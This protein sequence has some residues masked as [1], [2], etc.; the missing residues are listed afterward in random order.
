MKNKTKKKYTSE[1]EAKM[2]KVGTK[3][4]NDDKFWDLFT[5]F[6]SAIC[7]ACAK[8][9]VAEME[10]EKLLD[11]CKEKKYTTQKTAKAS[12]K[13]LTGAGNIIG[14]TYC[15]CMKILTSRNMIIEDCEIAKEECR[16]NKKSIANK[17][18]A[19]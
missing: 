3:I 14:K 17:K 6:T 13:K 12:L 11:Y 10:L 9:I 4:M 7:S 18:K 5:D 16:N 8:E 19:K 1:Q 2:L 15:D